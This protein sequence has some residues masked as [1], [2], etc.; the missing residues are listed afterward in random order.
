MFR[1]E[2][3]CIILICAINIASS[4]FV[5]EELPT[6]LSFLYTNIPP[7]LKGTD[8]RVGLG[9]RLGPNA[10]FQ[11]QLELGPQ[12]R[13]TKLGESTSKRETEDQYDTFIDDMSEKSNSETPLGWL[14]TWQK[15]VNKR[16]YKIKAN[17]EIKYHQPMPF[18]YSTIKHLQQLYIQQPI[19]NQMI[20]NNES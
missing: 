12:Q 17:P 11:V 18:D 14:N 8:S 3:K 15:S 16:M 20:V 2:Q 9:F 4:L 1:I 7:V 10:D 5:P 13:T 6:L 19:T